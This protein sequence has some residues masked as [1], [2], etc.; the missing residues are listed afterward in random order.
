[1]KNLNDVL[2]SAWRQG[3][4]IETAVELAKA[5]GFM[6]TVAQAGHHRALYYSKHS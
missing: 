5:H 2:Y 6:I 1:M 4:S 3:L